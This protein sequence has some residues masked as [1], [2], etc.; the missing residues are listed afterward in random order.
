MLESIRVWF[1]KLFIRNLIE[2]TPVLKTVFGFI[3]GYKTTIGKLG[4][5]ITLILAAVQYAF[6]EFSSINEVTLAVNGAI[7]WLLEQLGESHKIDKEQREELFRNEF[8]T[9]PEGDEPP[10]DG[11]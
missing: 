11:V 3:D 4:V 6:P 5:L 10:S 8:G 9:R 7:F 2:K 1:R